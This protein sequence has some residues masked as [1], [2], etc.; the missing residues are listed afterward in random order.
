MPAED[1]ALQVKTS[2]CILSNCDPIIYHCGRGTYWIFEKQYLSVSRPLAA[3]MSVSHASKVHLLDF[4][5]SISERFPPG[6][7]M[8]I[9]SERVSRPGP[10]GSG[11]Q[12]RK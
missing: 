12:F 4:S 10:G 1:R 6:Q 7:H 8:V 5:E 3:Q 9:Q 11:R 2:N